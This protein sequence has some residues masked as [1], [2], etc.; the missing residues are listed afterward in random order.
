MAEISGGNYHCS[1]STAEVRWKRIS[2]KILDSI[3]FALFA[4]SKV[5]S[6]KFCDFFITHKLLIMCTLYRIANPVLESGMG[7]ISFTLYW[8]VALAFHSSLL[9]HSPHCWSVNGIMKRVNLFSIFLFVINRYSNRCQIKNV[10]QPARCHSIQVLILQPPCRE[11]KVKKTV[12]GYLHPSDICARIL[13][14]NHHLPTQLFC[15]LF[16]KTSSAITDLCLFCLQE[17]FT[18]RWCRKMQDEILGQK[19][20]FRKHIIAILIADYLYIAPL[21]ME[22]LH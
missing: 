10:W 5:V 12:W 2:F 6:S 14:F 13:P 15:N 18:V 9:L 4:I 22:N 20:I 3:N 19:N 1:N 7:C 11:E 8:W 21:H 16:Y 17:V